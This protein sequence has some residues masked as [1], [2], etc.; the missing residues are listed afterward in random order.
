M[1]DEIKVLK[2]RGA[3]DTYR[4]AHTKLHLGPWHKGVSEEHTPL[5]DEMLIKLRERGFTSLVDFF[6]ASEELNI[7]G[8]GFTSREDFT[9]NAPNA[10]RISLAGMWH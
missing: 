9:Q 10:D 2:G 4:E 5:L 1:V 6:I 3:I 8:L 7:Q